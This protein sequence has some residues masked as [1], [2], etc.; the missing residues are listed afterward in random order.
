MEN[1]ISW[2]NI[3]G[4]WKPRKKNANILNLAMK[5][6]QSVNYKVSIR[7]VFYRLLQAGIYSKKS[8]Y[9]IL[10]QLT[11]K[12]RHTGWNGWHPL[13]LSDDTREMIENDICGYEPD[14]D[15]EEEFDVVEGM[16]IDDKEELQEQLD[17]F[18][19]DYTYRIDPFYYLDS[20]C[21]VMFEARAMVGQFQAYTEG[22]T[23]CPFGGFPSI[24]Y[25]YKIAKYLEA[26]A[27]KYGVPVT[28][29]YFGDLDDTGEVI[30]NQAK[31]NI[32]AWADCEV[33][34]IR[35][36]LTDEQVSQY[37]IP[38]NP[39][40]P[41]EYQW[42]A[43]SDEGAEEIIQGSIREY[44]D[45][46]EIVKRANEEGAEITEEIRAEVNKRMED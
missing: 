43:L 1:T 4:D 19:C 3:L 26:Q 25:K 41:G 44:F 45:Y 40:K 14:P 34:F 16:T 2:A 32:S 12:A 39:E 37:D 46:D 22:L 21:C 27:E 11:S 17:N 36:G 38:E 23:L 29:L 10:V 9:T 31:E 5:H 6:I 15:M 42:E 33:D 7:W 28:V 30:F 24:P 8:D 35:C 13:I 20:F 18:E